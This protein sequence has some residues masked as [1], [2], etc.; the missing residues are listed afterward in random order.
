MPSGPRGWRIPLLLAGSSTL[1]TLVLAAGVGEWAMRYRERTRTTVP[2]TMSMLF[3]RH[4]RLMHGLVRGMDYYGWVHIGRQ[5]FRGTRDVSVAPPPRV[6]RIIAAGGSTTFDANTSGDSSAWPARLE[7]AL[8]SVAAPLRFEV[9]NAGVP[10]F[11]VFDDLVRLESELYRYKPDLIILYQGHN[12]LFNTLSQG[13]ESA[14]TSFDPRPDEVPSEY[15]WQ[16]WLERHS[17]L[18]HKLSSKLEAISFRSSGQARGERATA[19]SYRRILEQGAAD[20]GRNV[21]TYLAVAQSLNIPVIVPQVS[22]A[23]K[24]SPGGGAAQDSTIELLWSR[25]TPFAPRS[26]VRAGYTLYDSAATTAASRLGA[27]HLPVSDSTLWTLD[28]Y[29]EGDPI[30]FNNKGSRRFARELADVIRHLPDVEQ[31]RRAATIN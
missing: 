24:S 20:Y 9:L 16:V 8:D 1:L 7:Q 2:G 14:S 13:T 25:A 3:Y 26:V 30:H 12:D 10:G 15:P 6:Y 18:Y 27:I 23:A 19:D 4:K 28:S 22:Y 29:A 21:R 5:G 31:R 17:L 11:H